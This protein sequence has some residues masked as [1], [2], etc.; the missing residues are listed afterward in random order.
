[1][2]TP[3]VLNPQITKSKIV[4][5]A[6]AGASSPLD[7]PVMDAFLESFHNEIPHETP[8]SLAL[9]F[10]EDDFL[11]EAAHD[12]EALVDALTQLSVLAKA[13]EWDVESTGVNRPGFA[14]G[15]GY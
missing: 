9:R 5:L 1:M 4:L 11:P 15:S 14:G 2:S 8:E 7:L 13:V 12:L 10:I 3:P 6:G